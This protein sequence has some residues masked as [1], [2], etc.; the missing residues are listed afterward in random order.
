MEL[1]WGKTR[2]APAR[3]QSRGGRGRRGGGGAPRTRPIPRST[4]DHRRRRARPSH[5]NPRSIQGSIRAVEDAIEGKSRIGMV[6]W[7]KAKRL[8]TR[9][10]PE[11]A[12]ASHNGEATAMAT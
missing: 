1:P 3:D 9:A 6:E 11:L 4:V 5:Q 7:S 10:P 12:E 8:V 2:P